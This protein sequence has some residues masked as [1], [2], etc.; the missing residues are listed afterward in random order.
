MH[1]FRPY[2][3]FLSSLYSSWQVR[4]VR[5]ITTHTQIYRHD[6]KTVIMQQGFD[7]WASARAEFTIQIMLNIWVELWADIDRKKN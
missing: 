5:D 7:N 2:I 1:L 3:V 4:S 6:T